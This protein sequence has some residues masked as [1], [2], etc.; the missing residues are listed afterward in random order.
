MRFPPMVA[1]SSDQ[2]SR[3]YQPYYH[4]HRYYSPHHSLYLNDGRPPPPP[5]KSITNKYVPTTTS[6]QQINVQNLDPGAQLGELQT[7]VSD[8]QLQSL[9]NDPKFQEI[10]DDVKRLPCNFN[11]ND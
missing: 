3:L 9:M 4:P 2:I 7:N 11:I 8:S 1:Y 10:L 6:S 5:L